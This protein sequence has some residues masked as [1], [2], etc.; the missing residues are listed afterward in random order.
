M[1]FIN[2]LLILLIS[3]SINTIS[4]AQN[5]REI[6]VQGFLKDGNGKAI[7]DGE[8]P[9]TFLI[10]NV[11]T[12]GNP[13]WQAEKNVNV[14][15][16]VYSTLLGDGVNPSNNSPLK[17]EDID[18]TTNNYLAVKIHGIELSPRTPFTYSPYALSVNRATYSDTTVYATNADTAN[19]AK[20]IEC[21]GAIGDIKYS[22][23]DPIEFA[24]VNG[25]CWVPMDGQAGLQGTALQPYLESQAN[26]AYTSSSK[27]PDV[28]G[29]FIRAHEH[30]SGAD[31]DPGRS[32][33]DD[34][35]I[36]Q[37]DALQNHTHFYYDWFDADPD[38]VPNG[39]YT[40]GGSAGDQAAPGDNDPRLERG[41]VTDGIF[42]SSAK[43]AIETRPKNFSFY[44]Y[45]RIN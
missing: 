11:A 13:I 12:G 6:S 33:T 3:F 15:G 22:I 7:P 30:T 42:P 20:A 27:V 38:Q 8:E 19:F 43:I 37:E 21:T 40:K 10:Y 35:A 2:I 36:L 25:D 16:G 18:W 41:L 28:S 44:A 32:S 29:A 24:K 45:I 31:R 23:L 26:Y 39:A 4:S 34:I 9:I 5:T 14:F 1:K 17:I